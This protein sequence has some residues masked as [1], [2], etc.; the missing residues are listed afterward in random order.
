MPSVYE[1]FGDGAWVVPNVN[2][3]P[4]LKT[5]EGPRL[6]LIFGDAVKLDFTALAPAPNKVVA[7][8]PYHI[9]TDLAKAD[10]QLML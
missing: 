2:L 8:I 1:L 9:T 3:K 4:F 6:E 10:P 7:N 5:L